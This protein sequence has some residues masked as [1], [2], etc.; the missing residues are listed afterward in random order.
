MVTKGIIVNLSYVPTDMW[1]K[2][3]ESISIYID[4]NLNSDHFLPYNK[5]YSGKLLIFPYITYTYTEIMDMISKYKSNDKLKIYTYKYE[6][7]TK[8]ITIN[9]IN[10]NTRYFIKGTDVADISLVDAND[11]QAIISGITNYVEYDL[12]TK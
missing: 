4:A 5:S 9:V 11:I 8:T 10:K 2:E 6:S 1:K 7:N 12:L 3:E